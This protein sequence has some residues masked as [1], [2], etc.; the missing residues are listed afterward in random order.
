MLER[1]RPGAAVGTDGRPLFFQGRDPL[2]MSI[3]REFLG[4]DGSS[5]GNNSS[6]IPHE[7]LSTL[8]EVVAWKQ[9][10]D[11]YRFLRPFRRTPPHPVLSFAQ[12]VELKLEKT[13][14]NRT[15]QRQD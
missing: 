5:Y 14:R 9:F 7:L 6:S 10:V 2:A 3:R 4:H 12:F 8:E 1:V 11:T 13:A 15:I